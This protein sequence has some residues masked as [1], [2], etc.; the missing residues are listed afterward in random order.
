MNKVIFSI[1]ALLMV[2]SCMNEKETTPVLT[3]ETISCFTAGF[4]GQEAVEEI[5]EQTKTVLNTSA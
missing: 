3:G 5:G 4:E 1:S 2:V